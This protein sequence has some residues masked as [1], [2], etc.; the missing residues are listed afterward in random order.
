MKVKLIAYT[1]EP[2]KVC[3]AAA[4][5]SVSEGTYSEIYEKKEKEKIL[6]TLEH[7]VGYGHN[8]VL[9]HASF[10]FSIEGISRA[11]SH[12]LVRHR[13]ASY[14]QQSQRYVRF[15]ELAYVTPP[16]IEKDPEKKKLYDKVMK[17][18]AQAYDELLK[19]EI[20]PEDAR[21][22]YP[23]AAKTNLVVSMNARELLH[24]FEMRCCENAQWEIRELADAML[25]EVKKVAPIIFKNAGPG[26]IHGQ[27][28][29]GT[30]TCGKI[31]QIREK[32]KGL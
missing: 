3:G 9:E 13:L 10:T 4:S 8:S 17:E 22:I 18:T 12:Q 20:K 31:V 21:Y 23:N 7:V 15:K 25:I 19:A 6:K 28:P 27:C 5:V 14:T 29:E 11:C 32:Y 2:E 1:P 24:F 16:A 30:K 26:C